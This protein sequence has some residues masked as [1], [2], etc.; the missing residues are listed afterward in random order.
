MTCL[1]LLFHATWQYDLRKSFTALVS[2]SQQATDYSTEPPS[3]LVQADG[4]GPLHPALPH[5]ATEPAMP[6]KS[7]YGAEKLAPV[8]CWIAQGDQQ[9]LTTCR[10]ST[11]PGR[12]AASSCSAPLDQP[13][14]LRSLSSDDLLAGLSAEEAAPV[15]GLLVADRPVTRVT[16]AEGAGR[17]DWASMPDDIIVREVPPKLPHS[18]AWSGL[19][20]HCLLLHA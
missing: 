8:S 14:P 9:G 7:L 2:T 3:P 15:R 16:A 12:E 5:R 19:P 1:I 4:A 17:A 10:S 13:S 11:V 20:S 6:F 18:T